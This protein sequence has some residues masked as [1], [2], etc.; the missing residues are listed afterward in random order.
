M[1]SNQKLSLLFWLFKA[2]ATKDGKA[3]LY[4]R[5]TIDGKDTDVSLSRKIHPN[6]WDV[7]HKK[8]TQPGTEA[9]KT[10]AKIDQAKV[11]LE[12]HFIVLQSQHEDITPSMLKHVYLGRVN[13]PSAEAAPVDKVEVP[14]I[15]QAF[16]RFIATFKKK[17][18]KKNR[19]EGTLRHWKTTKTKI[20]DF[21]KFKYKAE[22]MPL[23]ELR[24]D[25][26]EDFYDYLT[27]EVDYPLAE[28]T[29]NTHIKKT[30]QI[31]KACRKRGLITQNPIED[32]SCGGNDPEVMPLELYQVEQIYLKKITIKRLSE[33]RDAFI[34]QCFTGFAYQDI[35]ALSPENIIKVGSAGERWL[36]K[37]RGKTEVTEMVPILPIVEELIKKYEKDPY[38]LAKNCLIPINSNTRYNAYLKELADLCGIQREL[39]T[40][41]ARHT[42]ADIMLNNGAPLEDVQRMLGHKSIRTTQRYAKVRKPRISENMTK[43]KSALFTEIGKLKKV[44]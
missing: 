30:K 44:A 32:F 39:K 18:D 29:A 28:N 20:L 4:C 5:I 31:L 7:E 43:V 35:Y 14:T 10:N 24:Y 38:C 22:D 6:F 34:F 1:R 3:P 15:L 11:D 13:T 26:A 23:P 27:L 12:R 8:D 19:S 25:F 17:V 9:K 33:V 16:D 40:H 2:K 21:V 37:D 41:L 42:F 36:I